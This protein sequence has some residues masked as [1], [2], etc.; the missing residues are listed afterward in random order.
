MADELVYTS[1]A[2]GLK[3]GSRGFCIVAAT[4]NLSPRTVTLL[5]SLSAYRHLN[6]PTGGPHPSN[7]VAWSH[8]H[9]AGDGRSIL[10]RVAD[11][12]LD[13]SGRTNKLAHHL[14][15]GAGELHRS[16]PATMLSAAGNLMTAWSGEPRMIASRNLQA[17]VTPHGPCTHWQQLTGDAGWAGELAR[18]GSAQARVIVV[19]PA[20]NTLALITEAMSLVPFSQRWRITFC[21]FD[22]GL[23]HGM[24]CHWRFVIAGSPEHLQAQRTNPAGL[25]DLTAPLGPAPD[26]SLATMARSGD[27]TS[28]GSEQATT[29]PTTTSPVSHPSVTANRNAD[30]LAAITARASA[31]PLNPNAP[32]LPP[33]PPRPKPLVVSLPPEPPAEK[34]SSLVKVLVLLGIV[35]TLLCALLGIGGYFAYTVAMEAA[36][37]SKGTPKTIEQVLQEQEKQVVE[38]EVKAVPVE[39]EPIEDD[40]SVEATPVVATVEVEEEQASSDVASVPQRPRTNVA[41]TGENEETANTLPKPDSLKNFNAFRIS[42]IPGLQT[43]EIYKRTKDKFELKETLSWDESMRAFLCTATDVL[44]AST[45]I[46]KASESGMLQLNN[47]D[48]S[49]DLVSLT[50]SSKRIYLFQSKVIEIPIELSNKGDQTFPLGRLEE[51]AKSEVEFPIPIPQLITTADWKTIEKKSAIDEIDGKT[52]SLRWPLKFSRDDT[53]LPGT[54]TVTV[55]VE[56]SKA[57]EGHEGK[58]DARLNILVDFQNVGTTKLIDNPTGLPT[59]STYLSDPTQR[60]YKKL[61]DWPVSIQ[62]LAKSEE[63]SLVL[64]DNDKEESQTVTVIPEQ[65][66]V[67]TAFKIK[68]TGL[69]RK[70]EIK[71]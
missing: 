64:T 25:L 26:S 7:P 65:D 54:T 53:Q 9:L 61:G 29:A 38:P 4:A 21:T 44:G 48:Y 28:L 37:P 42:E 62:L 2:R 31:P 40:M 59:L 55:Q 13:Y 16:G 32:L 67:L 20:V 27:R 52:I 12:G 3:P 19:K 24:T 41:P 66:S 39:P 51:L 50:G 43:A 56:V 18:S 36:Q 33:T 30:K 68:V 6:L 57:T 58:L 8:L 35:G 63:I 23:P 49:F 45:T 70:W 60:I 11:A 10:S 47:P 71:E 46:M 17:G 1:A 5:E 14:V 15:L 22:N 34:K 69:P